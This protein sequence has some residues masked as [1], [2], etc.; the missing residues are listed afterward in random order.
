MGIISLI[1]EFF[2]TNIYVSYFLDYKKYVDHILVSKFI[3]TPSNIYKIWG[4]CHTFR[5]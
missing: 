4:S 1:H 5:K 2:A 3:E